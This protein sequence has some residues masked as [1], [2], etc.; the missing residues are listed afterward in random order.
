MG[1]V[2][3]AGRGSGHTGQGLSRKAASASRRGGLGGVLPSLPGE[4]FL[5]LE[6]WLFGGVVASG[7]TSGGGGQGQSGRGHEQGLI[8]VISTSPTRS[9]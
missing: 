2:S 9:T 7:G 3:E 4:G 1:G 8:N 5:Q 6:N